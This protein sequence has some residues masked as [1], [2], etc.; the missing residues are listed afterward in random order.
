M[1]AIKNHN[2]RD[3]FIQFE[4]IGHIYTIANQTNYISVTSLI[5]SLFD[6]FDAN[7]IA[8]KI[9]NSASMN[10]PLY[11]YFGQSLENITQQWTDNAKDASEKGTK[12]HAHIENYYNGFFHYVI[13]LK[14]R[15]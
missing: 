15:S 2:T 13:K 9:V 6:E 12:L 1:L 10:N 7:Q 5:K 14:N 11:K 3:D 4:E 8:T